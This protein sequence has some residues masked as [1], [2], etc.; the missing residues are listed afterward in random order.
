MQL[1]RAEEIL[2]RLLDSYERRWRPRADDPFRSLIRIILNQNTNS[3]N[4]GMAYRRLEQEIGVTPGD[5]SAAPVDSIAEAIRPAGMYNLRSVTIK[6]VAAVV[7]ERFDGDLTPVLEKPY[8]EAR[9]ILMS[10]PGVGPKT[11]DVLL[12]FDAGKEVVPVDRHIFRI[13]KRLQLVPERASYDEVRRALETATPPGRHEDVH[14][15]LIRFGREVCRAQRPRC[16]ECFLS[17]L[18]PFPSGDGG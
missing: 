17:D 14:V 8:E 12:M 15:L 11:A 5:I 3:R 6:R 4:E 2:S 18:C 10:L 9:E 16:P 1:K 13:T 7:A